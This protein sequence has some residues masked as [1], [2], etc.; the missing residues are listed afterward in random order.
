MTTLEIVAML[1]EYYTP[2]KPLNDTQVNIYLETLNDIPPELL[3]LAAK[4]LIKTGHPFMPKVA[5]IRK[6]I[7]AN[8]VKQQWNNIPKPDPLQN[9]PGAAQTE[10]D[11]DDRYGTIEHH[12]E[13]IRELA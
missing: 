2:K 9:I 13:L 4:H 6:A 12:L 7:Y 1:Q 8:E 11:L 3:E 10:D 5:E